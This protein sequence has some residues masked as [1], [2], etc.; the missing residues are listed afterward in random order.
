MEYSSLQL[1]HLATSSIGE[2]KLAYSKF[3]EVLITIYCCLLGSCIPIQ[4]S[5]STIAI[6]QA[7]CSIP[8]SQ[9]NLAELTAQTYCTYPLHSS[10]ILCK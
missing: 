7:I 1:H 9:L 10:H 5:S 4:N 6:L 8:N 2:V 3:I